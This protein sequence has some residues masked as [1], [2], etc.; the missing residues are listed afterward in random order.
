MVVISVRDLVFFGL[1]VSFAYPLVL[2]AH[3]FW[4]CV[5]AANF[6]AF[7]LIFMLRSGQMAAV[8]RVSK[9]SLLRQLAVIPFVIFASRLFGR[10]K[11]TYAVRANGVEYVP[12]F[13][14]RRY[15]TK[16]P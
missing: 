4:L 11:L 13:T 8:W 3:V 9:L 10:S 1:G 5:E 15:A 12:P 16:R 2:L 6:T 7:S 14:I